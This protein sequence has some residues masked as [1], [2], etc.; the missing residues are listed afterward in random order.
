MLILADAV[1]STDLFA[2]A[3]VAGCAAA[4]FVLGVVVDFEVADSA[5]AVADDFAAADSVFAD[6]DFAAADFAFADADFAAAN[7]AVADAELLFC[8][9][10]CC[11]CRC[12]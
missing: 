12:C 2:D 8:C 9:C 6:A 4:G 10:K 3:D 1:A 7:V 11:C 5:A